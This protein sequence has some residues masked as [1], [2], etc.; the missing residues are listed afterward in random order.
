MLLLLYSSCVGFVS[1]RRIESA[2]NEVMAFSL[3][4]GNQQPDHRRIS[5]FRRRN[6]DSQNDLFFRSYGY[7]R[8]FAWWAWAM[9]RWLARRCRP[10]PPNT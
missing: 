5:E 8:R 6:L 10:A 2:C 4:M 9:C 3:L 1:S 7:A